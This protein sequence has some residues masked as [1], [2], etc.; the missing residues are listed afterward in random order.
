MKADNPARIVLIEDSAGDVF[1][2]RHALNAQGEPFTL[3]VVSDGQ[4]AVE[5]VK[6]LAAKWG[7]NDPCVLILDLHLPKR[8]GLEVLRAIR[9]IPVLSRLHVAVYTGAVSPQERARVM[10]LNIQLFV[11]KPNDVAGFLDFAKKLFE[12]CHEHSRAT[13]A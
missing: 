6:E 8:D 13:V 3:E 10:E 4:R 5:F 9:A 2:L 7:V 1:L 12:I 11:Q